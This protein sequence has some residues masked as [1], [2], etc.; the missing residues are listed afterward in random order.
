MEKAFANY[1]KG[2]RPAGALTLAFC[3]YQ[4]GKALAA[5]AER[6]AGGTRKAA[7][8]DAKGDRLR[9]EIRRF[10]DEVPPGL[11]ALAAGPF[12]KAMDVLGGTGAGEND[13][14]TLDD[15]VDEALWRLAPDGEK[16]GVLKDVRAG[17]S[18][19]RG[20]D[21]EEVA[22]TTV[23]KTMRDRHKVPYLSL[24]YY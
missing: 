12:A 2:G 11:E 4:V 21:P 20:L 18:G 23:V 19:K 14:E 22:R 1:R 5:R 8:R 13:L 3:E 15:E 16:A 10:L 9:A 7:S 17:L 6:K 24:Y